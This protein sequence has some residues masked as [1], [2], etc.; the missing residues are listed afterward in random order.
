MRVQS[1]AFGII[2]SVLFAVGAVFA[3]RGKR[4]RVADVSARLD[5]LFDFP[6]G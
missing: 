2:M 4:A 5:F 1:D 3:G 6:G